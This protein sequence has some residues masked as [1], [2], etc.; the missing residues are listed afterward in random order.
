[1]KRVQLGGAVDIQEPF[2]LSDNDFDAFERAGRIRLTAAAR[3]SLQAACEKFLKHSTLAKGKPKEAAVRSLLKKLEAGLREASSAFHDLAS[4]ND[5]SEAA[6]IWL[7]HNWLGDVQTSD[8]VCS[9][10]LAHASVQKALR[11]L[12]LMLLARPRD[13]NP[14]H[15]GATSSSKSNESMRAKAAVRRS[16]LSL[17]R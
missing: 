4:S 10:E 7:K 8:F 2:I 5:A 13:Q 16:R 14:T 15:T 12:R 17:T 1:M 11:E 6:S 9:V 3:S